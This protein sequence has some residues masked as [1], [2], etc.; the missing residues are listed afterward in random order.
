MALVAVLKES[1]LTEP[2][3]NHCSI[4][5][6]IATRSHRCPTGRNWCSEI[7]SSI[8]QPCIV[9]V[10]TE[11]QVCSMTYV[12]HLLLKRKTCSLTCVNIGGAHLFIMYGQSSVCSGFGLQTHPV[13]WPA[14]FIGTAWYAW[15]GLMI[16]L[17]KSTMLNSDPSDYLLETNSE[18][19]LRPWKD[20]DWQ[21]E[22]A[23]ASFKSKVTCNV[24]NFRDKPFTIT[25]WQAL[26]AFIRLDRGVCVR[27]SLGNLAVTWTP[28]AAFIFSPFPAF[29][30]FPQQLCACVFF[31][32][33]WLTS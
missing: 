22:E 32:L 28:F 19:A 1:P 3:H 27:F 6:Y 23:S 26:S 12:K 11:V 20:K 4:W 7:W 14:Q 10:N 13:S 30:C 2:H 29:L 18:C 33:E 24:I 16:N 21:I 25:A 15:I 9:F 31:L 17:S 5:W 8:Q